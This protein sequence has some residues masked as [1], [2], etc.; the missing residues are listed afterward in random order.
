[1]QDTP[2][3]R[4]ELSP[5][6]PLAP[7]GGTSAVPEATVPSGPGPST[8]AQ[9]TSK[10]TSEGTESL[11]PPPA[12]GLATLSPQDVLPEDRGQALEQLLGQFNQM[13]QTLGQPL[14]VERAS[15]ALQDLTSFPAV[16]SGNDQAQASQ[17]LLFLS[18]QLWME[19]MASN[20][21]SAGTATA[22]LALFQ[23]LSNLLMAMGTNASSTSG[24]EQQQRAALVETL[25]ALP[26]VQ[27][28]LLLGSSSSKPCV[29]VDSPA[30]S[31][32]LSSLGA[33]SL[34]HSSF[35][36][37]QPKPLTVTFPSTSS[38]SP[39]LHQHSQSLLQVQVASFALDPFRPLGGK[40]MASV[41][42]IALRA[43]E[44]PI[45]MHGLSEEIEIVLEG[46]E[47]AE[48]SATQLNGARHFGVEANITSS[49]DALLVS[50]R[51][52]APLQI[53]LCLESPLQR[54]GNSCLL[55]TTLPKGRWQE[56]GAYVW[57][58]PPENLCHGQ[59]TYFLS[60]EVAPHPQGDHIQEDL[61]IS[62]AS[63]GCYYWAS[64][65]QAWR[66]DG[67]R[68]GL[69]STL[70]STQCLCGHLS[71]FGRFLL[72]LPHTINLQRT[73]QLLSKVGQNP[74]GLALL[75]SLLLAYGA[76]LFWARQRQKQDRAKVRV[77]VLVDNDASAHFYYLVQVFTGYRRGA[78]T[79]AKVLLTLY[80]AEG[81]SEPHLLQ[82]PQAPSFE[83]G[84]MDSFL[85]ATQKHLGNLHAARLWHNNS[86][87]NPSWFVSRLVVSDLTARKKWY[88]LCDCWLAVDMDDGQVDKVFI[89]ASDQEL[90]SFGNLFWGGL[91]NKLTQEHL[92]LS[93]VTCS[94]WSPFT[95]TQRLSC[96]LA[97]LLCS[98]LVNIMFWKGPEEEG[99]DPEPGPFVVTWQ[100]VVVSVEAALLLMPLHLL[101]VHISQVVQP[102]AQEPPPPPPPPPVGTALPQPERT[103]SQHLPTMTPIRQLLTE[104]VGFLY[105]NP[106]CY[107]R[108]P[109]EFPGA[110][111]QTPELVVGLCSLI[112]S[113]LQQLEEPETSAQEPSCSL[114]SYLGHVV[115]D[116]EAQLHRRDWHRL[117]SPSGLR[118]AMGQLQQLR[119]QLEQQNPCPGVEPPRQPSSFPTEASVEKRGRCSFGGLPRRFQFVCWL[120]L[121]TVS[122]AS[123][124]FT[125]LYSLQLSRVQ[126]THWVTS[127]VLS[128][129]Q[130]I[131]FMQPLKATCSAPAERAGVGPAAQRL[132]GLLPLLSPQVVALTLIF[133]LMRRR[134]LWQDRGQERELQR[135]LA[136]VEGHLHS[137][138]P[139]AKGR[140]TD[141]IYRPPPLKPAVQPKGRALREKRLYS[142]AREIAVQLVFLAVLMVL[143]YAERSPNEFYLNEALQ[144]S[145]AR[146]AGNIQTL[147]HLYA[148]AK[149]TLLP[150]I[151]RDSEGFATDGNSFL[152]GSVRLRQVRAKGGP[153][154]S[155]PAFLWPPEE[156]CAASQEDRGCFGP[157][158][159]PAD[160]DD[161][162]QA[163]AWVYQTGTAL[164]EFPVWGKLAIYPGGG[165]LADLGPNATHANS[166]LHALAQDKWLDRCTR[167]I[168]IEFTVYNANVDLFC[169]VTVMLETSGIGAFTS[170]TAL[171]ILRLYPNSQM[172][173][174]LACAQIVF[175][176]LL[177]YYIV[178]QGQRLKEQR[179][180]YFSTKRN[181]LDALS[182]LISLTVV[183]LYVKRGVLA[184][185]VLRRLRR[186]RSSFVRFSEMAEA[187]AAL[188][189]LIAFLV[190]L[191]TIQLWNLLRLNPRLHLITRTLQVAWDEI[192]GFLLTLLVL[193]VGYAFACNLM[194]GW[195]IFNYKTF[196]DSVVTIVGLL[197]GIFNYEAVITLDPV[198]GSLLIATS[199][200]SMVFVII[201]LF[202]SALL[203][204]FSREMK[205]VKGSKEE[206]MIQL[207]QLKISI[208]FGIKRWVPV[209][210][211][212]EAAQD[213]LPP[214][215]QL[216]TD[217]ARSSASRP[218]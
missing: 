30:L 203:T 81:R 154:K 107:R 45:N 95:R 135:A 89:P 208:L 57:V 50:V 121:G 102:P 28:G 127:M 130:G 41:A 39:L 133:S 120:T 29:T 113:Y 96:C 33:T 3:T 77:T 138:P 23:S 155:G 63:T 142:L 205:A 43:N 24:S 134:E 32:T 206:S 202:V 168:F 207:V 14:A 198:L 184:A 97:L 68:V 178:V 99:R 209:P 162:A 6:P 210:A 17:A 126:A 143:C 75:C 141:G 35:H 123:G 2:W 174:Q 109:A 187:D 71:F 190:A 16:L 214:P 218:H 105:K 164:Q 173:V 170:S 111:K 119:Q 129:L 19:P 66:S 196:F 103:L 42:S 158:W 54:Q 65:H 87:T 70:R 166:I 122:L 180:R 131:F 25:A 37:P 182:V 13:V 100:E 118:Q 38:L 194:F 151:Y 69:N 44:G 193:L 217:A 181:L 20:R 159:G 152:V 195:S 8:Q 212:D 88:F 106:Q 108:E 76:L 36:L 78:A 116:L 192:L 146:Q 86:G 64:Q 91:V 31:T 110:W 213:W 156:P 163:R 53:T 12:E 175:L 171:Q 93:V 150:G 136:L 26:L 200:L 55:N 11:Q 211:Q 177:L 27:S 167:A 137:A 40:P 132:A 22:A 139:S 52:A 49:E 80:G 18:S 90:L 204:I 161:R 48:D 1:M 83:Q 74:A 157:N 85:L 84:S 82:Q 112:C 201:N 92:W 115:R 104:T 140:A 188:T 172:L 185:S 10:S 62:I 144:K 189:Y 148:W 199:V 56:E 51:P 58:V 79:S 21:S 125:V 149:R 216:S 197:V 9:P 153:N 169:A 128:V 94:P 67:C 72:I 46:E 7:C 147:E 215:G 5:Y 179:W 114:L 183:G 34:P 15:Q 47:E 101:I 59:G 98:M 73:G 160:P 117:Q 4:L 60:A 61:S 165:Y 176:L 145:F 124:F 186:D 191:T